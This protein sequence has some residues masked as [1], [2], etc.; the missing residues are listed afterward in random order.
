MNRAKNLKNKPSKSCDA[1][2]SV[3]KHFQNIM[4]P[5]NTIQYSSS[6]LRIYKVLYHGELGNQQKFC[7]ASA[8]FVVPFSS[9]SQVIIKWRLFSFKKRYW[10]KRSSFEWNMPIFSIKYWWFHLRAREREKIETT[11]SEPK[12]FFI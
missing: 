11:N 12:W 10:V 1:K 9:L 2:K 5:L 7:A 6:R 8:E 4:Q 3:V